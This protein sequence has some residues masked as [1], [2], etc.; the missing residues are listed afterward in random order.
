MDS[1]PW[2]PAAQGVHLSSHRDRYDLAPVCLLFMFNCTALPSSPQVCC[3]PPSR[4]RAFMYILFK[5]WNP[6]PHFSIQLHNAQVSC[7]SINTVFLTE[8]L[9]DPQPQARS[10]CY[11][12][13]LLTSVHQFTFVIIIIFNTSLHT[14]L[15]AFCDPQLA[16]SLTETE[17][18]P[19][20]PFPVCPVP[21]LVPATR[22]ALNTLGEGVNNKICISNILELFTVP[23]SLPQVEPI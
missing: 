22:Q 10:F 17:A 1:W 23:R 7:L 6:P 15:H 12:S 19:V 20:L 9:S 13:S 8:A 18:W 4:P 11:I 5:I 21:S 3:H 16:A 14:S 2:F